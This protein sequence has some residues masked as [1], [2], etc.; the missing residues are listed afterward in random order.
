MRVDHFTALNE[1][2]Q[3][4]YGGKATI[5]SYPR[6]II[7]RERESTM[8][9]SSVSL[10]ASEREQSAGRQGKGEEISHRSTMMNK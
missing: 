10:R 1:R 4:Y 7:A 2:Y 9:Y 8:D 5:V 6:I 3:T